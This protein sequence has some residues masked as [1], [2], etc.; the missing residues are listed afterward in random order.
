MELITLQ[1]SRPD[2]NSV[3][4]ELYLGNKVHGALSAKLTTETPTDIC[5]QELQELQTRFLDLKN[6]PI[7]QVQGASLGQR[8]WKYG[9]GTQMY[10]IAAK[11]VWFSHKAIIVPSAYMDG[12]TSEAAL[13]VW[14]GEGFGEYVDRVGMVAVWKNR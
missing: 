14:H 1:A 4:I 12:G 8:F 13:R 5:T 9:F 10:T 2:P 6:P 11:M 7:F 3:Y